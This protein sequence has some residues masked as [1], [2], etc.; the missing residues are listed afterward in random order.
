MCRG[1]GS[2]GRKCFSC[3]AEIETC[4][5]ERATDVA[6]DQLCWHAAGR[7][8]EQTASQG[9]NETTAELSHVTSIEQNMLIKV[10]KVLSTLICFYSA[11]GF[12]LIEIIV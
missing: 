2:Q 11:V 9:M 5:S 10:N 4:C 3:A 8:S 6:S 7:A 12:W 1:D